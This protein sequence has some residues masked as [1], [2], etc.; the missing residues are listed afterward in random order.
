VTDL[1]AGLTTVAYLL[2]MFHVIETFRL[3]VS[4]AAHTSV[5]WSWICPIVLVALAAGLG[6]AGVRRMTARLSRNERGRPDSLLM[7]RPRSGR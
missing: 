4:G 5:S 6:W 2:P 1:P 3:V 7:T